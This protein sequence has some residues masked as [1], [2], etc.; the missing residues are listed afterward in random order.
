MSPSHSIEKC[1][2]TSLSSAGQV[3]P[4]L[5]QLE[6][7]RLLGVEQREHLRVDDAPA[8]G[9]PLHVAPPEAGGGA[10]RVGVVD[11]AL[12]HVGDG[13]EAAVRVVREARARRA[14]GTSASRR[15]PRS[16]ARARAPPATPPD[17]PPRCPAG[18]RRRGARRTGTDRWSATGTPA[19]PSAAPCQPCRQATAAPQPDGGTCA[20][21]TPTRSTP[22]SGRQLVVDTSLTTQSNTAGPWIATAGRRRRRYRA[23]VTDVLSDEELAALALAAEPSRRSGTTPCRSEPLDPPVGE[24]AAP[25]L[26]HAGAVVGSCRAGVATPDRARRGVVDPADQRRRPL[27]DLRAGDLRLTSPRLLCAL[28]TAWRRCRTQNGSHARTSRISSP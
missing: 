22:E 8:G 15:G 9:E 4:D 25:R 18:T 6:R 16:P 13:L 27:R 7:V 3:E 26:V 2:S 19:A 5:E 12:A 14:R 21:A 23:S 28:S 20:A 10:Q 24:P 1:G 17:P 11:E